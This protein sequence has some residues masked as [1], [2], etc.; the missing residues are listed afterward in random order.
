LTPIPRGGKLVCTAASGSADLTLLQR[1]AYQTLQAM[2]RLQFSKPLPW[3]NQSL[4]DWFVNTIKGIRFRSDTEFSFC[5]DPK[6][7]I[8]VKIANNTFLVLTD[9]WVDPQ[10]GDGLMNEVVLYVHE[11]RHN[12]G[13]GHTCGTDDKTIAELGAWGCSI[14]LTTGSPITAIPTS[15]PIRTIVRLPRLMPR[16]SAKRDF[17]MSRNNS[18]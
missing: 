12:Q 15:S 4:Y 16:S 6:D 8:N 2:Q 14:I 5:C 9:R 3:T 18:R 17:A 1:R 7:T 13:Y 10:T 11:A